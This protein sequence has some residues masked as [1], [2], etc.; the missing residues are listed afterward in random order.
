MSVH[1][2]IQHE[3]NLAIEQSDQIRADRLQRIKDHLNTKQG[4]QEPVAYLTT[5]GAL[6][7]PEGSPIVQVLLGLRKPAIGEAVLPLYWGQQEKST[8]H[9]S[10]SPGPVNCLFRKIWHDEPNDR[11]TCERCG[12]EYLEQCEFFNIRGERKRA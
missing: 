1:D 5:K 10:T 6:L 12:T 3:L 8:D 11:N 4:D 9:I 7:V 2:D